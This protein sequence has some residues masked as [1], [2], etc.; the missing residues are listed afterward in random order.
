VKVEDAFVYKFYHSHE[1]ATFKGRQI[2]EAIIREFTQICAV[3]LQINN[4]K[5]G[6]VIIDLINVT[7]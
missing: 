5:R 4:S 7:K 3:P 1:I 6:K 2:N